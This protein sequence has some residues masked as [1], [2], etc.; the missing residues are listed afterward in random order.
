MPGG[1]PGPARPVGESAAEVLD[2]PIVAVTATGTVVVPAPDDARTHGDATWRVCAD[3]GSTFTKVAVVDLDDRRAAGHGR[4]PHHRRT[5]TCCTAS[6]RRSP[7]PPR[8]S[9]RTTRRRRMSARRPAAGCGSRSSATSSWSRPRP[10]HRVGLSAGARVVHVAAG[11]LDRR[12]RSP[13]LRAARP[14]VVLLVGGTDGGDAEVLRAQ[15]GAGWPRP[16]CGSR[17]WSPATSTARRRGRGRADRRAACRR[18]ATDN[19]LPRIGELNPAPAR[20]A[21]REVFLRHVI[22]GKRLSRG[23]RFASLVRGATPDVVLTAVELLA[24]H[25]RR[26]PARGRRRRRH[27]R[28]VLGAGRPTPDGRRPTSPAPCGAAGP[29]RV[30]WACAGARRRWSRRPRGE[31]LLTRRRGT[32]ACVA[33][34]RGRAGAPIRRILPS[35]R[36]DRGGRRCDWPQL[37]RHG[38]ACAGTPRSARGPAPGAAAHRLRRGAAASP[39]GAARPCSAGVLTDHAGGWALP[40]AAPWS[41]DAD[42]VLA[43]AGLLAADHPARGRCA[44]ADPDR[45]ELVDMPAGTGRHRNTPARHAVPTD[46]CIAANRLTGPGPSHVPSWSP[47]R[48]W[49]SSAF[50]QRF[51]ANGRSRLDTVA[52][53]CQDQWWGRATG[54]SR[55]PPRRGPALGGAGPRAG[56][57]VRPVDNDPRWAA[58]SPRAGPKAASAHLPPAR[59]GLGGGARREPRP[60]PSRRSGSRRRRIVAMQDLGW[61]RWRAWSGTMTPQAGGARAPRDRVAPA[62]A[63]AAGGCAAGGALA[64]AIAAGLVLLLAFPPYGLWWLAPGRGGAARRGHAPARL[65]GRRRARPADRARPASIPLLSWAGGY[66]GPV[67]LF[68]PVGEARLL[69]AA[70]AALS[71]A[72]Q[73]GGATG[74]RWTLAAGRPARCG[75]CRRRCATGPRSAASRGAGWR[76]ARATRRCCAWPRSAAPRW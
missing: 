68:L 10:G 55:E 34:G 58:S 2:P 66:V 24:D 50:V 17:W 7:R 47:F 16:G 42:Y 6:T 61:H 23:P 35:D 5:P 1:L 14:D 57:H 28:R 60:E 52:G 30:T 3:V 48:G 44:A 49:L 73:P 65:L 41:I 13:A 4:A 64:A 8:G 76:S 43:P 15:R 71:R 36:R 26:R 27:D 38:R 74:W 59:R 75:C 29:S 46:D 53:P 22:G 56:G 25:A 9:T 12:R 54:V 70:R 45:A 67:W 62:A 51:L 19:V 20:A 37:G 33:A 11:R 40:R 18:C 31:R 21:I 63:T 39:H 32:V 72:G 69:R